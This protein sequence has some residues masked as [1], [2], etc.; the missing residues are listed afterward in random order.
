MKARFDIIVKKNTIKKGTQAEIIEAQ[1][2]TSLKKTY[3]TVKTSTGF[4]YLATKRGLL[5]QY[6]NVILPKLEEEPQKEEAQEPRKQ[7]T[8]ST[9][10]LRKGRFAKVQQKSGSA[11]GQTQLF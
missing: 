9:P 8:K 5:K 7:V 3:Y 11:E 10:K 6:K 1:H 4:V 2:I